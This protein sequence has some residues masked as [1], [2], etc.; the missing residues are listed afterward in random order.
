MISE[1]DNIDNVW[2]KFNSSLFPKSNENGLFEGKKLLLAHYTSMPIFE[3]MMK[4]NEIWFSNPLYM[5]DIEEVRRGINSGI[6]LICKS[7]EIKNALKTSDNFYHFLHYFT[8]YITEFNTKYLLDIYAFCLS[9][10]KEN[11]NDGKLSMW[12]GYGGNGNGVAIT[13][14]PSPH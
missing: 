11:D 1:K 8:H 13:S 7:E 10:H 3:Q 2:D 12:R 6:D 5:N 9:E 14:I 4:N